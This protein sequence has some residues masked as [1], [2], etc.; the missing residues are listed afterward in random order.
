MN[1]TGISLRHGQE[2][3]LLG[4]QHALRM[5]EIYHLNGTFEEYIEYLKGK[6]EIEESLLEP[7]EQED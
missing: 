7:K 3:R 5:A 1:P 2:M 6:V 4:L